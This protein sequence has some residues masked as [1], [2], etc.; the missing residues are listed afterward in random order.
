MI[1]QLSRSLTES[2]SDMNEITQ[3]IDNIVRDSDS[4]LLQQSRLS[5]DLEQGLMNTRLLPFTGLVPRFERIIRQVNSELGKQAHLT[6]LGAERELDR[7][8]LDRI[9]APLEHLIRNAIAHG[10]ESPE[11]RRE[12]GKDETGQLTLSIT[13]EGSE[14]LLS[15]ADDGQGIDVE[16]VKQ[17]ALK[18][19]LINPDKMPSDEE[20]IQLILTSGFS[21]SDD[22]S[23]ISGRGVG[24]DVV[25]NEIRALKGRLSIQSIAG[26]GTTFNVRLP[27][28]LSI[29][30]SLMVSCNDK[31]YA[32]PMSAVHAGT[33]A[34]V[35]DIKAL[36][37]TEGESR[38]E[39]HGE[40]Y[41]F[42]P[43][44]QLLDQTITLPDD[45]K[46]QLPI[47]L[48]RYGDMQLALLVDAVN[49]NRE[50][51]LKSV[52]EQLSTINS[53]NGATI[54]GDGQVV[55]ILDIP[56]LVEAANLSNAESLK[57]SLLTP[58]ADVQPHDR[59][60][61]AMVVDDSITMRK[62]SGNLLKRHGFDVI[63]A[64]D[65]IDAIAQL[66]E[67][68][69]DIIL[70]DVEMPRMDGFEFATLV[71]NIEQ[72]KELPIIMITSRTGDKHRTRALNIGVNS[73]LGK[74]YQELE[75]V[76]TMQNLLGTRYP[77]TRR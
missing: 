35:A 56:S 24:M 10:V 34:S 58:A 13:R 6:V 55:F 42:L 18:Q 32:I 21:T 30:Q 14:I 23:Q 57:D 64:R 2:V 47:L 29:M 11:K 41:Q 1:Q 52:G 77:D 7:T 43:L 74:P 4:I 39:F 8:I 50:I 9:V 25:S 72:Y 46:V 66:N 40:Y 45:P 48:F 37:S 61:I 12:L 27:L 69:P 36:L 68:T 38:F 63:T 71:R 15:L 70:L 67:Q 49:A 17:K 31:P 59:T 51:V 22:V 75:L 5:A 73:Y 76:E 33:R 19:N 44:A 20:L 62:V 60:P 65:G 26:K 16:K 3:S 28:T 54:L 53:I